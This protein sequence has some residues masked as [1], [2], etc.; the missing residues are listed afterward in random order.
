MDE[1]RSKIVKN[2]KRGGTVM[3]YVGTASLIR[4]IV[5]KA[6][7]DQNGAMQACAIF[8][9]TVLTLGIAKKANEWMNNAIDKV[10]DFF[11]D[12]KPRK[13]EVEDEDG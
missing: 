5:A 1:K 9:G 6:R 3:V 11:D 13:K 12:V 2:V 8:G 7:E 4:P 10:I